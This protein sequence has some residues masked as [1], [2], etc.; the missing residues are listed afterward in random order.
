[1]VKAISLLEACEVLVRFLLLIGI[2]EGF[3]EA[4]FK[5]LPMQFGGFWYS[6]CNSVSKFLEF[7]LLPG[8]DSI[9]FDKCEGSEN[10]AKG[11]GHDSM[12]PIELLV[13]LKG[14]EESFALLLIA[15]KDDRG[16]A[17]KSAIGIND[18]DFGRGWFSSN[19]SNFFALCHHWWMCCCC[20]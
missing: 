8:V 17:L 14:E 18:V 7:V 20:W 15:I 9:S 12:V 19:H 4:V 6:A 1:V 11:V 13:K 5:N 3:I 10:L 16:M 2:G